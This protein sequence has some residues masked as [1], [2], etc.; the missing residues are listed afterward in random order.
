MISQE[1]NYSALM[2]EIGAL[3]QQNAKPG[4]PQGDRL[5]EL[6]RLVRDFERKQYRLPATDP[7]TAIRFRME[8]AGLEP[9]DLVPYL[10]SR[11][12]VSEV[13][14]G[15]RP[16]TLQMIRN[17]H[18]GLGIPAESLIAQPIPME[19]D[20]QDVDWTR[21]PIVAMEKRGWIPKT[22]RQSVERTQVLREFLF[23]VLAAGFQAVL[24]RKSGTAH[25]RAAQSPDWYTIAAWTARILARAAANPPLT[26]YTSDAINEDFFRTVAR[27]SLS[28]SGPRLAEEIL[29]SNGIA[30]IIEPQL[31]GMRIDGAAIWLPDSP[32]VVALTLRFDRIDSFW[33]SLLH[34]L[35]HV[36][37]HL[38]GNT[39]AFF[40]DLDV[41]S[42]DEIEREADTIARDSLVPREELEKSSVMINPS[43]F[44]VEN[45]ARK[46]GIHPAIVAGRVRHDKGNYRLLSKHI[47][48][49][50]VRR[51]FPEVNWPER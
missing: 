30:F 16:L 22:S 42:D 2:E 27:T 38:S 49:G 19:N 11:S 40:D 25:I 29:V 47:G 28:R 31:P 24:F 44:I 1:L 12:R 41:L 50:E 5:I 45:L 43:P 8:Q 36:A 26:T 4:T 34:E 14:A 33:H 18:Q 21:F 39:R 10:G 23:P 13:L 3:M 15:K 51:L 32:P 17:L 7:I 48:L 20:R 46:L 35:A 37:K 6:A 9:R